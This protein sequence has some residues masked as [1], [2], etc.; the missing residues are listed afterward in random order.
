MPITVGSRRQAAMR[1]VQ[2][3]L[4][5]GA[6]VLAS[7]IAWAGQDSI[8]QIDVVGYPLLNQKQTGDI[9][10]LLSSEGIVAA[11]GGGVSS[12]PIMRG[13][14]D[15]RIKLLI[16][17]AESTSACANHMNPAL[18]YMDGSRVAAV[19][20]IAGLAPV[21][22][23]GDS[24]AGT[25]AVD[26]EPP[27][28][29][30]QPGAWSSGGEVGL[31][32]RSNNR[33]YAE[34]LSAW[35]A[36]ANVSL[37]YSG[38]NDKAES[39]RDGNGDTVLDTL[40]RSENHAL[41]L[42]VRGEVQELVLRLSHQ[43]IPYQG[44]PNQYM[45]M[46]GNVSNG[47]NLQYRH[48]Y[49]W[50][51]LETLLNWQD[52]KHEMGFFT[53]EKPGV[54]PMQTEGRDISYKLR[55]EVPVSDSVTLRIGNEG[56][57]FTLDDWWPAVDGFMMMGPNDYVNINDGERSRY[58]LYGEADLTFTPSWQAR[59]GVRYER[60]V[61]D[62][63]DVQPY[64][65]MNMGMMP[66]ADAAA[67]VIFNSRDR[68]QV[69]DNFDATLLGRY[70][71]SPATSIEFG[72]ARKTRSPSLY[73]RYSWGRN[74]M[75]MTMIGWFGDGNGYVGNIDLQPEIAH[76]VSTT[77]N[78]E[79]QQPRSWQLSLTPWYTYVDDYI[80]ADVIGTLHPRQTPTADRAALQLVNLDAELYGAEFS[81]GR[82]LFQDEGIGA[83]RLLSRGAYTRGSRK[84]DDSDLYRIMPL[85]ATVAL[86]HERRNWSSKLEVEWVSDKDRV[87]ERR[88]ENTTA[89][90]TLVNLSTAWQW[91]Q[92]NLSLALRNLTDRDYDLPLGG[93]YLSGWIADRSQPFVAL[94]GQGRSVD[95]GL[96]YEF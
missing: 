82:L 37:G 36:T 83:V 87:D 14:N 18:S 90:Y 31:F 19:E 24:I 60:V 21:S 4:M 66:N 63:G 49:G 91:R 15:D 72:Y 9:T 55:A 43:E 47:V 20:V 40:Y 58:A 25:I 86:E 65:T 89:S 54:M 32:Y 77:L 1:A 80:D 51:T 52:V 29:A 7:A 79:G 68:R 10:R 64:N 39:Y 44:F 27:R 3:G 38:S 35:L 42:G 45:D 76:T 46:V 57:R 28:Y 92:L 94:P 30:E 5:T 41:T 85:H 8:E 73:E 74:T 70:N 50:G 95:V 75:A 96:R 16:N 13:L 33:N 59:A 69:D 26:S 84:R 53:D 11:S 62:T 93:V 48:R 67:A 56:H 17:G 23:G 12:L 81:A 71:W 34:S 78:Y 2:R 61:T 88:L 6:T 22:L